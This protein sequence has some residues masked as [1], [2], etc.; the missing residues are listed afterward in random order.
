MRR[1]LVVMISSVFLCLLG[2]IALLG[3]PSDSGQAQE[4]QQDQEAPRFSNFEW[5]VVIGG[6]KPI[7]GISL[8]LLTD[9]RSFEADID[10]VSDRVYL[11]HGSCM[12]QKGMKY[13]LHVVVGV[14]D[15]EYKGYSREGDL[16][17]GRVLAVD[18]PT[19]GEGWK[20]TIQTLQSVTLSYVP[21]TDEA[22]DIKAVTLTGS[23]VMGSNPTVITLFKVT[24]SLWLGT[25]LRY[26]PRSG[27]L[28]EP[29]SGELSVEKQE[30][31]KT[32]T[33][34]SLTVLSEKLN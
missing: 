5:Y 3:Q 6:D 18:D 13:R 24:N 4:G 34:A 9:R 28:M 25:G 30:G 26:F 20:H 15:G 1:L 2:G 22:Q 19:Q 12:Y 17:E 31:T 27:S 23:W 7:L 11:A 33:Q 29:M 8:L 10:P 14:D 32:I 21:E 16:V